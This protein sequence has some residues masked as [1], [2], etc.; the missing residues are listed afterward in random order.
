MGDIQVLTGF[1]HSGVM[2]EMI[3]RFK[4]GGERHLGKELARLTLDSWAETPSMSDFLI[5]VPVSRKRF[6]ER[7]YNQAALLAKAISRETGAVF[8]NPLV[9]SSGESQIRVSGAERAENI[10][11]KFSLSPGTT[12]K[13]RVWLIDDV[14]TTGATI[15]EIVSTLS[16]AGIHRVQ[17]GV[18]CFRKISEESIIQSNMTSVD[19][20]EV[21]HGETG[22]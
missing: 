11:G 8:E 1:L 13:G 22:I 20:Q 4:F 9:R 21:D 16:D 12:Y 2:R 7:G 19:S 15:A 14:M 5:P 17:P 10:R 3:L 18:V 6:R